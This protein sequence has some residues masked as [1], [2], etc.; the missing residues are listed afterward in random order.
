LLDRV[1]KEVSTRLDYDVFRRLLRDGHSIWLHHHLVEYMASCARRVPPPTLAISGVTGERFRSVMA[2]LNNWLE[3]PSDAFKL[4]NHMRRP[5]PVRV[6]TIGAWL[7]CIRGIAWAAA[8]VNTVLVCL[9]HP[10][11]VHIGMASYKE[12]DFKTSLLV[13]LTASHAFLACAIRGPDGG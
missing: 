4:S 3:G 7:D 5:V 11:F 9:Y 1:N 10:D 2:C 8:I 13:G 12:A 6:E